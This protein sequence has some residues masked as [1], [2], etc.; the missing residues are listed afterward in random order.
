MGRLKER[1]DPNKWTTGALLLFI[2]ALLIIEVGLVAFFTYVS[3]LLR[4][5]Y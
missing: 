1:R 4:S 3:V 2:L 5:G